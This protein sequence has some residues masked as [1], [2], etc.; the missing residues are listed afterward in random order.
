MSLSFG[1]ESLQD[2][3]KQQSDCHIQSDG[4]GFFLQREEKKLEKSFRKI[5]WKKFGKETFAMGEKRLESVENRASSYR[6][7]FDN[8]KDT[9]GSQTQ[10][11]PSTGDENEHN[12]SFHFV[13][14]LRIVVQNCLTT[15]LDPERV[16]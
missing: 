15:S 11:K 4:N 1:L 10:I 3:W 7:R 2:E 9:I 5:S 8:F 13:H 14:K 12:F 6:L 16:E